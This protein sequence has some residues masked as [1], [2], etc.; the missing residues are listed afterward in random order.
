M[1]VIVHLG[2]GAFHRAHQAAYLQDLIN[3]GDHSWRLVAGNIV[4]GPAPASGPYTLELVAPD[5]HRELR[6]IEAIDAV[7]ALPGLIAIAADPATAIVSFTVTEAG[8]APDGAL[9]RVL[10]EI[11]ALRRSNSA[12]PLTL[13]CCD[14]LRHNGNST[15]R[16]LLRHLERRGD[17]GLL[18][19][20]RANVSLPN[21]MVDRITP[22]PAPG[23]V[24]LTA[25]A[26]RQWVIEDRF[27]AGRPDWTRVGVQM[28]ESVQ[29]FE[30]AKIR[31]L[32]AGH[33]CIAWAGAL[34]GLRFIHEAVR[35]EQILGLAH[36][37]L[38]NEVMPVLA[39]RAAAI[40]LNLPAYRDTVLARFSN[41]ALAD[42]VERVASDS[43]A[44]LPGFIVP[45][46]AERL[47]QGANIASAAVPPALFLAMLRRWHA[48]DLPF[49]YRDAAMEPAQARSI[50]DAAD[51]VAAFCAD[52]QLWGSLA[53][54]ARLLEA[55]RLAARRIDESQLARS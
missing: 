48:G 10:A 4:P 51:P 26:Y 36:D 3:L 19:W 52:G 21:A 42:T 12:G 54:D 20:T 6:R 14:N 49:E 43:F 7:L 40:G 11:L 8:Y 38:S 41:T 45:T 5:G 15:R 13:L 23:Q 18:A 16:G 30:E 39:V 25:E 29:G 17:S 2:L 46:L 27:L 50:C 9:Y 31:M 24:H 33:S 37:F 22:R 28:V 47:A 53:G 32:N 55:V 44:K 35:D 34:R 1:P